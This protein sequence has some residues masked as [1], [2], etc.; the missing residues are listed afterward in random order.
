MYVKTKEKKKRLNILAFSSLPFIK[1]PPFHELLSAVQLKTNHVDLMH[2]MK[3]YNPKERKRQASQP[4]CKTL[5][6][7]IVL[8]TQKNW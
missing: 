6:Q 4:G 1:L 5:C 3:V 2:H 7:A 8:Q